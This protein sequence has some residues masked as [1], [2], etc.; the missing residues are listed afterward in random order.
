[1]LIGAFAELIPS[2]TY[3]QPDSMTFT[4]GETIEFT[5][6]TEMQFKTSNYM[7]FGSGVKMKFGTNISMQF[8]ELDGNGVLN[9]CDFIQ[10]IWPAGYIPPYCSWWEVI[11][12]ASGRL[13]GEIHI[14]GFEPPDIVHIDNVW[15][16]PVIIPI[17][18][19]ILARKKIDIIEPCSYFEV[20]WPSHWWPQ[21]CTWWEIID[22]FSGE[23]TGYEF[24]VDW[25]NESC[26]FHVDKV[27]PE[28]FTFLEPIP[29]VIA[30]EKVVNIT[31]CMWFE[32]TNP[33]DLPGV[34]TWWE[35][36]DP[37][38]APTDKEFYVD[39][40]NQTTWFHIGDTMPDIIITIPPTYIV[41]TRQKIDTI[42]RCIC[43]KSMIPL[44][45]R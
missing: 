41:R 40:T 20:H 8:F 38:G 6:T 14:D 12:P 34:G 5:S 44:Q 2:V 30:E 37:S 31:R 32:V 13:L 45:L 26:E 11:D 16:G 4:S 21:P 33:V 7:Q 9:I 42:E 10:V 28:P 17:G 23:P 35:I 24:H 15:P 1:M 43:T 39:A 19:P 3:A 36:L 27:I 22:P 18:V 29:Y 25:T